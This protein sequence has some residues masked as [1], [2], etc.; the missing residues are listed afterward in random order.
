MTPEHD[1]PTSDLGDFDLQE[2]SLRGTLSMLL[3]VMAA[4]DKL[5][6]GTF[7]D[8]KTI[9]EALLATLDAE[10]GQFCAGC[11]AARKVAVALRETAS[12]RIEAAQEES[13]GK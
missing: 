6:L 11:K 12:D 10:G 7:E 13:D 1:Q 3:E 4:R 9:A 2:D 5:H 8:Q